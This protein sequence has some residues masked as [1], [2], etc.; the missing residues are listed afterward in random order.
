[1]KTFLFCLLLPSLLL[2]ADPP[3]TYLCFRADS[4]I[5]IDGK[6]D[7]AAWAKASWTDAFVDI[8]GSQ[9]PTPRLATRVKMLWDERNLYIAAEL[10]EPQVWATIAKRDD[11]IFHDNDFEMFVDPDGDTH[12]YGELELNA[13][14]TVWDL[15]LPKPY[16]DG[17]HALDAWDIEG[18]QTAVH[19][20]GTLNN[21]SDTDRG[22]SAE[23]AVPWRGLEMCTVH[24][25]PPQEGEY[26][27]INFSRVEWDTQVIEAKYVKVPDKP[28]FNW[29]WSPQGVVDM[30]RPE[31]WGIVIFE[32][33]SARV[34]G[35]PE[36][37]RWDLRETAQAIYYAERD[38]FKKKE[39]WAKSLKELKLDVPKNQD[40]TLKLTPMGWNAAVSPKEAPKDMKTVPVVHIRDDSYLWFTNHRLEA[41]ND[42]TGRSE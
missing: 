17:G 30:H 34:Q 3:K 37:F 22:W 36:D 29:V 5:K 11:V 18:L 9:K 13:L 35:V 40:A 1:V 38:F 31:M 12:E 27:R 15:Y 14:N 6:L 24:H 26:W 23:I 25:R 20:D 16:K 42:S 8:E 10:E 33:D 41:A 4:D 7:D 32:R 19:V 39:K 21:S 28:E 2:A